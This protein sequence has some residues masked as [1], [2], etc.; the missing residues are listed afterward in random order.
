MNEWIF[1]VQLFVQSKAVT[2]A[3]GRSSQHDDDNAEAQRNIIAILISLH[4]T[5]M[6]F[7]LYIFIL[8]PK[9]K[10]EKK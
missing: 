7:Y 8:F 4:E 5:C 3:R 9:A 2:R 6:H 1:C 10:M